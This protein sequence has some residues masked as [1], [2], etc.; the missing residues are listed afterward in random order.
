[1][2]SHRLG[3]QESRSRSPSVPH[4]IS[5]EQ[6]AT[7]PV[8]L[9]VIGV[10]LY[11]QKLG[12]VSLK[13]SPPWTYAGRGKYAGKRFFLSGGA[14]HVGLFHTPSGAVG[15]L[16]SAIIFL[17]SSRRLSSPVDSPYADVGTLYAADQLY[18]MSAPKALWQPRSLARTNVARLSSS[19]PTYQS[20]FASCTRYHIDCA[21]VIVAASSFE[22]HR[23]K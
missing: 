14:T 20:K 21:I 4:N 15:V 12:F 22:G 1:M 16:L 18:L 13:L 8:A 2:Y 11:S 23:G 17:S 19:A 6:G 10:S 5:F 9:T 7:M 3:A